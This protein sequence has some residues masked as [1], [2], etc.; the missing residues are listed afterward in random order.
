MVFCIMLASSPRTSISRVQTNHAAGVI[1]QG[2]LARFRV[3]YGLPAVAVDP[4]AVNEVGYAASNTRVAFMLEATVV[5][6]INLTAIYALLQYFV[7][8][9]PLAVDATQKSRFV[10]QKM[11]EHGVDDES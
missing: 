5:P 10:K 4:E 7:S 11:H 1:Y 8:V 2:I 3:R 9:A 6:T